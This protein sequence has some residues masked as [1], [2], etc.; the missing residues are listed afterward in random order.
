M[1]RG[2][3]KGGVTVLRRKRGRAGFMPNAGARVGFQ[4]LSIPG[5]RERGREACSRA[6]T[7]HF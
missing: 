2:S 4:Q 1:H 3:R 7:R 6:V 5:G